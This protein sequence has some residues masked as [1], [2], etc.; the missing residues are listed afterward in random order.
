MILGEKL[1]LLR[2][3]N[4]YSLEELA[5]KLHIAR[6]TNGDFS[7]FQGYEDIFYLETKIYELHFHGG[8]IV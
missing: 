5:D 7:W 1:G 8:I 3:Q 6:Q 4:G 2:K